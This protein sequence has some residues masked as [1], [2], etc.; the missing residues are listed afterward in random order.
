MAKCIKCKRTIKDGIARCPFCRAEQ[1]VASVNSSNIEL[2][3]P[4]IKQNKRL[5]EESIKQE[6][7][8]LPVQNATNYVQKEQPKAPVKV[9]GNPKPSTGNNEL[10]SNVSLLD[11]EPL[12]E[13][14][15]GPHDKRKDDNHNIKND[16][17]KNK[18][19]PEKLPIEEAE[20]QSSANES[21]L[22]PGY[23]ISDSTETD[24]EVVAKEEK[25][26]ENENASSKDNESDVTE[27]IDSTGDELLAEDEKS[28]TNGEE[29]TSKAFENPIEDLVD[30]SYYE[31]VLPSNQVEHKTPFIQKLV[32]IICS[33]LCIVAIALLLIYYI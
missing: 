20:R 14:P 7:P 1:N 25:A 5:E 23:D 2:S 11:E 32:L 8:N 18:S 19:E 10:L 26:A 27:T 15:I 24:A 12:V 21:E 29:E 28:T 33:I 6:V 17:D 4:V 22:S 13:T 30:R 9:L 3:N 16:F 31:D